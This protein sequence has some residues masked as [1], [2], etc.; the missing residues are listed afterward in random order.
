MLRR[1]GMHFFLLFTLT[2]CTAAA[3]GPVM[4]DSPPTVY[5]QI[6]NRTDLTE[7]NELNFFF[8]SFSSS[9]S[10]L[11]VL[12]GVFV[13]FADRYGSFSGSMQTATWVATSEI[14]AA[15]TGRENVKMPRR[16]SRCQQPEFGLSCVRK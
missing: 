4:N 1:E 14:K 9:C 8:S 5:D 11:F 13:F 16:P 6:K 7:V 10:S 2:A 15:P 3:V 12:F